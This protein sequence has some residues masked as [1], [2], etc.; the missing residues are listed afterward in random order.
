LQFRKRFKP[1]QAESVIHEVLQEKLKGKVYAVDQV[2]ALTK[3]ISEALKTQLLKEL[4][5]P[6][7]KIIVQVFSYDS[8][9]SS[10]IKFLMPLVRLL[11]VSKKERGLIWGVG[12]FG[13]RTATASLL[14]NSAMIASFAA[15]QP[16]PCTTPNSI[17]LPHGCIGTLR[18][19]HAVC[20]FM[21]DRHA[22]WALMEWGLR[23]SFFLLQYRQQAERLCQDFTS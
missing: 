11:F 5:I 19:F 16:L 14:V 17:K 23:V 3:E 21:F 20:P 8:T 15:Q 7:Y 4:D 6:R 2:T 13:I 1:K 9:V 22:L 10:F 18:N 12:A